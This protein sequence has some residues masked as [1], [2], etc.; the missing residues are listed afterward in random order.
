MNKKTDSY[1]QRARK[2]ITKLFLNLHCILDVTVACL[3]GVIGF[4][5]FFFF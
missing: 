2:Q 3:N 1:L 5:V 4:F